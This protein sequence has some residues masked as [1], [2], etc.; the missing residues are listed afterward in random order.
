MKLPLL[1]IAVCA[2]INICDI[3]RPQVS[4]TDLKEIFYARRGASRSA[5]GSFVNDSY[6]FVKICLRVRS[7]KKHK[8]SCPLF[9]LTQK[10]QREKLSKEKHR[11]RSFARCDERQRLCL[12]KPQTFE[13]V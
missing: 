4:P 10:V 12:L 8:T 11:K 3:G 9:S 6:R 7:R 5:R 1:A 13:K 2:D